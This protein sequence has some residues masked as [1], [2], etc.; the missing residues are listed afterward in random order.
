MKNSFEDIFSS[1]ESVNT[2]IEDEYKE[3]IFEDDEYSSFYDL[4]DEDDL[5]DIPDYEE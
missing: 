3:N 1:L 4:E 5:P 2:D